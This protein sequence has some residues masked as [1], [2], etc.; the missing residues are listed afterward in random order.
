MAR[1]SA[2]WILLIA[3]LW[4]GAALAD[5]PDWALRVHKLV[6]T[7]ADG[8]TELGSAVPLA[9]DRLV[10]NCHVLRDAVRIEVRIGNTMRQVTT[11]TRDSYRDLCFLTLP[12]LRAESMPM[13]DVGE[14]R[15][16]LEVVAV[17]YPAGEFA[18]SQ[19]RVIGLHHCECDGGKV[20][21]TSAAFDRGASGGRLFDRQGRLVGFLAFKAKSGGHFHFV[22]PV[23][24]LRHI[25]MNDMESLG[26]TASFWER[27]G[28]ESGYFLAACDLGAQK[29][30]R[31]LKQLSQEWARQ[32]PS[33]PE[34][35]MALGRALMGLSETEP[36]ARAFRR[37]LMLDSTHAEAEW[38]LQQMEFNLG[39]PIT[40][41]D[42]L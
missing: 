3:W 7:G 28:R 16:G 18:A 21:Q 14:T 19:G 37:V 20:I 34:A 23:G 8:S 1:E 38:S 30:W 36:A 6:A 32:E 17:G 13:I 4:T 24:W 31:S 11:D 2:A 35:W 27:P 12:G 41:P 15:V 33:N 26:D 39:R 42:G 10:T 25:A 29:K 40:R 9:G 22:L 5:G